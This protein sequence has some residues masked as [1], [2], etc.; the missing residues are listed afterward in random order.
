M[1]SH[2]EPVEESIKQAREAVQQKTMAA[3]QDLQ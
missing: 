1:H 2:S 3:R